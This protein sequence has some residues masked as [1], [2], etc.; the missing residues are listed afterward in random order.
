MNWIRIFKILFLPIL[1]GIICDINKPSYAS[2]TILNCNGEV[3]KNISCL[4]DAYSYD[5]DISRIDIC[6]RD[7]FPK[8]RVTPDY[9]GNSCINLFDKNKSTKINTNNNLYFSIP[10]IKTSLQEGNYKYISMILKNKFTV[11][12][13]YNTK[14]SIYRTGPNG[15]KNIIKDKNENSK[16]SKFNEKLINWRGSL[17][18]DNKYCENGGS[19]S[20]CDLNYNG[21][22]LTAI[23]ISSTLIETYGENTK[24]IFYTSEL[25]PSIK[26][27]SISK[28]YID[29]KFK[30]KLEVYGNGNIVKSISIAPILFEAIYQKN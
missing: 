14:D 23:G 3:P 29:I 10:E 25:Q 4:I 12:E 6:Q 1:A 22:K 28:G 9:A 8:F 19:F 27:D 2:N 30:K 21:I 5:L 11:F 24:F 7:P 13:K 18:K 15:P 20:R 17:N 16:P 26:L